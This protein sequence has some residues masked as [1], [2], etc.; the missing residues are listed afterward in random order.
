[1]PEQA[2]DEL[3]AGKRPAVLVDLN[4]Y[5]YRSTVAVMSSQYMIGVSAGVRTADTPR[6]VDVPSDLAAALVADAASGPFF[7]TLSNSLQR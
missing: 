7:A 1:M 3:A 4:G 6:E 2:I 5:Q